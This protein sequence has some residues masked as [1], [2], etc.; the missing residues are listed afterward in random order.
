M[1]SER[2]YCYTNEDSRFWLDSRVSN[3]VLSSTLGSLSLCYLMPDIQHRSFTFLNLQISDN[4]LHK[5]LMRTIW[6]FR[7]YNSFNQYISNFIVH[8]NHPDNL[9]VCQFYLRKPGARFDFSF[10][11]AIPM[12]SIPLMDS[13][14][15]SKAK[16]YT[17]II[18]KWANGRKR[19]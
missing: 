18:K 17:G 4:T 16:V 11:N 15:S 9:L 2:L 10:F 1:A 6:S 7:L 14:E 8:E 5:F 19:K 3:L 13:T 12:I